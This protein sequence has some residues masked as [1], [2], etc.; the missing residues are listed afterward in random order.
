MGIGQLTTGGDYRDGDD[1]NED[2]CFN[3]QHAWYGHEIDNDIEEL[4]TLPCLNLLQTLQYS[5]APRNCGR[6]Q[7]HKVKQDCKELL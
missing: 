3:C 2:R 1:C 7:V 4:Y 6:L 5:L